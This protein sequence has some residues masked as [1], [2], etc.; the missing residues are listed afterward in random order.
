MYIYVPKLICIYECLLQKHM[1][2][3]YF[4]HFHFILF[5]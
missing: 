2:L 5:Y 1:D 4:G 3:S